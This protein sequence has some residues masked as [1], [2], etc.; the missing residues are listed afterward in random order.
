M[1]K[2]EE[3]ENRVT[4]KMNNNINFDLLHNSPLLLY[5]GGLDS[6]L[7]GLWL[8]KIGFAQVAA[9][10]F[11]MPFNQELEEFRTDKNI[12]NDFLESNK[13][14]LIEVDI[15]NKYIE[16]LK[17]PEYGY[18]KNMNPCIDCKILFQKE[19]KILLEKF[20]ALFIATGEVL[21]QRPMS[22]RRDTLNLIQNKSGCKGIIVRP[23]CGKLLA[24]TLPE[25]QGIIN[26]SQLLDITGRGR[27][28]QIELAK[29]FNVPVIPTPAGGCLLTEPNFAKRLNDLMKYSDLKNL[30]EIN[31]LRVGRHFRLFDAEKMIIGRN[32]K[33]NIFLEKYNVYNILIKVK[34]FPGPIVLYSGDTENSSF[35]TVL[36]AAIRYSDAPLNSEIN[37]IVTQNNIEKIFQS[38]LNNKNDVDIK[39][40]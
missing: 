10:K 19:A 30:N 24:E 25:K 21:G 1:K 33:E 31:L 28:R 18:G 29:F 3:S 15:S 39:P 27:T 40:L 37:L 17:K 7:S 14:Y 6:I 35:E 26:R 13:I 20:N 32:E 38:K 34:D 4:E 22:Q 8:R 9:I 16:M 36:K 23:L 11:L 2:G 12:L 5:S